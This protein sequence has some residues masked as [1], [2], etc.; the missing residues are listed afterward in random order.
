[1]QRERDACF[2]LIG[3]VPSWTNTRI[4]AANRPNSGWADG[5]PAWLESGLVYGPAH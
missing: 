1:M 5:K 4:I 3:F 2:E